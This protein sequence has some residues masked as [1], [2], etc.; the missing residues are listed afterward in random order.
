MKG[1]WSDEHGKMALVCAQ[2]QERAS[3]IKNKT[4]CRRLVGLVGDVKGC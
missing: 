1:L 4:G 3:Q 2:W